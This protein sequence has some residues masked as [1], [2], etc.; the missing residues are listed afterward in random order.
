M[1]VRRCFGLAGALNASAVENEFIT[2]RGNISRGAIGPTPR[3]LRRGLPGV[4]AGLRS[5]TGRLAGQT[6]RLQLS[7]PVSS[8]LSLVIALI[9]R[10]SDLARGSNPVAHICDQIHKPRILDLIGRT[11]GAGPTTP[12]WPAVRPALRSLV[13]FRPAQIIENGSTD[14]AESKRAAALLSHQVGASMAEHPP[15]AAF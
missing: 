9:E 6:G 4:S 12:H 14:S 15:F 1:A 5:L 7:V 10:F 11:Q 2:R 8:A 3:G 13:F